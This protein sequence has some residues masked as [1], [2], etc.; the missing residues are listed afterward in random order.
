MHQA[1]AEQPT[2]LCLQAEK[3]FFTFSPRKKQWPKNPENMSAS[4]K[5]IHMFPYIK[6]KEMAP[7]MLSE[8]VPVGTQVT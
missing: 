1:R 7:K 2:Q 6:V 8:A 5:I 3:T 4:A